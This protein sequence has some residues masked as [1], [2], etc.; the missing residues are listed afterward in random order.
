MDLYSANIKQKPKT[1]FQIGKKK[2][3]RTTEKSPELLFPSRLRARV[4]SAGSVPGTRQVT[5]TLELVQYGARQALFLR[6]APPNKAG[7][8]SKPIYMR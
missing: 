4:Q 2:R 6:K 7:F 8:A 1:S 3:E 5:L